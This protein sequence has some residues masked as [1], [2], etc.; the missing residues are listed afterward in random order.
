MATK[1]ITVKSTTISTKFLSL[2]WLIA[3][4]I[5]PIAGNAAAQGTCIPRPAGMVSWWPGEGNALDFV[6][7]NDGALY[8]DTTFA[9]GMVGQAFSFDGADDKV[10]IANETAFNFTNQVSVEAWVLSS[11]GSDGYQG[12]VN[13]GYDVQG[14]FELRMTRRSEGSIFGCPD[15]HVMGFGVRGTE[16][17]GDSQSAVACLTKGV[18]HHLVG[19]Y[20]GTMMRLYLDGEIVTS[21][22]GVVSEI[23]Y[24]Y[25]EL[26]TNDVPISIGW[27]GAWGEHWSGLIDEVGIYN[28]A[29]DASEIQAIYDA[30]SAGKCK[31]KGKYRLKVISSSSKKGTGVITSDDGLI[32]CGDGD[33]D[34][35]CTYDYV[36]ITTVVLEATLDEGSVFAGWTPTSLGCGT[37][38][39]CE[40]TMDKS[41]T[42]KAKFRGPNKLKVKVASKKGGSGTVTSNIPGLGGSIINCPSALCENYYSLQ[43]TVTITAASQGAST[44]LGWKPSSL[45]CG[46]NSTCIVPMGCTRNVRAVFGP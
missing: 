3:I 41:R 17:Q 12:V 25:G 37:E 45:G 32:S 8:F 4:F 14:P 46:I 1:E 29:L 15:T 20:D 35:A 40:V 18:W 33:D 7:H 36:E 38:P 26:I 10:I 9:A 11:V 34:S 23:P 27:N 28:R 2:M 19:T 44:F 39:T 22:S 16:D 6:H 21:P 42:V 30:G 5:L 13:K 24:S 43:E 31:D